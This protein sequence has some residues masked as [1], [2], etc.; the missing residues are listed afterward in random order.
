MSWGARWGGWP[1]AARGGDDAT[2][3]AFEGPNGVN[4]PSFLRYLRGELVHPVPGPGYEAVQSEHHTAPL[5]APDW[6]VLCPLASLMWQALG[7]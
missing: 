5:P 2:N 6:E 1:T 3:E 7:A 4:L